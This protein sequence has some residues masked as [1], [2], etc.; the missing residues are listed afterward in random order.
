MLHPAK[1]CLNYTLMH[2]AWEQYIK[3]WW[4]ESVVFCTGCSTEVCTVPSYSLTFVFSSFQLGGEMGG[5]RVTSERAKDEMVSS[6]CC[7]LNIQ[8]MFSVS[9][10]RI[11]FLCSDQKILYLKFFPRLVTKYLEGEFMF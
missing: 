3:F 6:H 10:D 8:K 4:V 2:C 9:K 5:G 7:S 11:D 1:P